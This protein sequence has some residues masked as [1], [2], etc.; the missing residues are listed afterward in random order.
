MLRLH[1]SIAFSTIL[2]ASSVVFSACKSEEQKRVDAKQELIEN[3]AHYGIEPID[4]TGKQALTT[5]ADA[6][7]VLCHYPEFYHAIKSTKELHAKWVEAEQNMVTTAFVGKAAKRVAVAKKKA[8]E[9]NKVLEQR[10]ITSQLDYVLFDGNNTPLE[11]WLP[12]DSTSELYLSLMASVADGMTETA[13]HTTTDAIKTSIGFARRMWMDYAES[14]QKIVQA[15]PEPSRAR[16]ISAVNN[17]VRQH[18]IDLNNRYYPYYE[19]DNPAWLLRDD[20][21]DDDIAHYTFQG[22]HHLEWFTK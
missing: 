18:L 19:T 11:E 12:L 10:S 21:T 16:Y 8:G 14:L 20:A 2:L 3:I 9:L 5:S 17:I 4:T 15:V 6:N 1:S 7:D 22:S 13:D